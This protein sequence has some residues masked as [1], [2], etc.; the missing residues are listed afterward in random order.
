LEKDISA[1]LFDEF[2]RSILR[3]KNDKILNYIQSNL[4]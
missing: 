1:S 3:I 2:L 4:I